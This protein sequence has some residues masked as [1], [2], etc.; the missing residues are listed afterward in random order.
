MTGSTTGAT[1]TTRTTNP[2]FYRGS[3]DLRRSPGRSAPPPAN[4]MEGMLPQ[5]PT[6]RPPLWGG[7]CPKSP[8]ASAA[9]PEEAR[10]QDTTNVVEVN[11]VAI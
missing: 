5:C 1:S 10:F 11:A 3:P 7:L 8:T 4:C 9:R 2:G 6:L